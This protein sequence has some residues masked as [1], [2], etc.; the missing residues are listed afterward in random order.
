MQWLQP[1][2][3]I[4]FMCM[5]D[6]TPLLVKDLEHANTSATGL[7]VVNVCV[8]D[9]VALLNKDLT[10]AQEK[11]LQAEHLSN[12]RLDELEAARTQLQVDVYPE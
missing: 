3:R 1:W 8:Q 9:T 12:Q 7:I 2:L 4:L 10:A 6:T 5:R 11:L